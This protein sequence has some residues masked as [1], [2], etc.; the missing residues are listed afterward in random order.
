MP[1]LTGRTRLRL[2]KDKKSLVLQMEEQSTAWVYPGALE[3][4]QTWRDARVEDLTGSIVPGG[5]Q[6]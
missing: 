3:T 1:H 6:E 4:T 5:V 2:H